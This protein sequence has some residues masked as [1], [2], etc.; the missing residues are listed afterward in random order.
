MRLV[1]V[2]DRQVV[3]QG[4]CA[5]CDSFNTKYFRGKARDADYKPQF[6]DRMYCPDCGR[7]WNRYQLLLHIANMTNDHTVF[8]EYRK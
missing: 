2:T 4:L 8:F 5:V 7:D 3:F 1:E 6:I